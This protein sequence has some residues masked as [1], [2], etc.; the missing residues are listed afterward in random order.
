MFRRTQ[1][2][3]AGG[4]A[5]APAVLRTASTARPRPNLS[6]DLDGL[7]GD[8]PVFR[9]AF[10]GY[11]R[12]EVDNHVART[13][14]ELVAGRRQREELLSRF[15]TSSAELELSR[16]LLAQ[17]PQGREL[18]GVSTR[19]GEILRLAAD[20]AADLTTGGAVEAGRLVAEARCTA[21][22]ILRRAHEVKAAAVASGDRVRA[23]AD[24]ERAAAAAARA[25]ARAEADRVLRAAAEEAAAR[26]TAAQAEID[27]LHRQRELA[28]ES[29][30]WLTER[31][32]E[33]LDALAAVLPDDRA[34]EVRVPDRP[35]G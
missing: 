22:G 33:A 31:I 2:E 30:R 17:S 20:E 7:L 18:T 24:A 32:G 15:T 14:A 21:D 16:R 13:E 12:L 6:G 27:E 5:P 28:R 35:T 9:T 23:E 34:L 25:D 3:V 26:R 19:V 4:G 11:D 29:L 10:W 8:R 1:I